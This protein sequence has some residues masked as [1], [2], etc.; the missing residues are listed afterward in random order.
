VEALRGEAQRLLADPRAQEV[1]TDF[2]A[3]WLALDEQETVD[4]EPTV[5]PDFAS[6]HPFMVEELKRFTG[7][8]MSGGD[9][10]LETLL[11]APFTMANG[12]L[13]RV[14]GVA[15]ASAADTSWKKVDLDPAQRPGGLLTQFAFL[16]THGH[17]GAAPIFRGKAVREQ[18]FCVDLPPPPPGADQNLPPRTPTQTV[19]Q[20]LAQHR[21]VPQCAFCHDLM[22]K[23]G[24]GFDAYDD[25]GRF[26]TTEAGVPADD[27]GE[28][29]GTDVDGKFKGV[30]ELAGRLL[31]SQQ[32]QKCVATQWF[33]YALGR[34][35]TNLD[36]CTLD[37][38]QARFQ[39]SGLRIPDLLLAL[40]ESDGFRIR[41]AEGGGQ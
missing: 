32:V 22:D 35:E 41:R 40:V 14:Y 23:M 30:G 11:T 36:Q 7:F 13:A 25:M 3:R 9:G 4:K 1:L 6:L 8:V 24:Y 5:F 15:G 18:I 17:E 39:A 26:R 16:A 33:R 12:P 34:L 2:Y 37:A 29:S 19:R 31:K 27:S 28:I 38:V 20:R 21:N 10:K